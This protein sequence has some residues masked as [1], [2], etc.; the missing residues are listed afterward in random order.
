MEGAELSVLKGAKQVLQNARALMVE[1][2]RNHKEVFN[3]LKACDFI[4]LD[5]E[6]FSLEEEMCDGNKN[7]FFVKRN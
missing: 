1:V 5:A 2:S 6:G 4:A 3:F 7:I